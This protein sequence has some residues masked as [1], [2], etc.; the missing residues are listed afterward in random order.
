MSG[1]KSK[2]SGEF[3]EKIV[4]ELL[5][6]IGWGN[7]DFNPTIDCIDEEHKRKS[8]KHGLDF[9]FS[10][11][12]S[13]IN[14]IQDDVLISVKHNLDRYPNS[15]TS[16]FKEYLKDLSQAM[17]CFPYDTIYSEKQISNHILENQ[18]S[19]VL[20]W[21]SSKD[22]ME[23]DIV[24][25]VNL[26]R[27]TEK[28]N[29]G[30][31]YLVDNKRANFLYKTINYSKKKFGGYKFFYHT[32]GYNDN[33]PYVK[34]D[35][36]DKLPVQLINTNILPIRVD[37]TNDG[38]TLLLFINE[39]FNEKSLKRVMGFSQRLTHSWAKNIIILFPDYLEV[40]HKNVVQ[41][42]KRLFDNGDFIQTIKVQS[43]IENIPSLGEE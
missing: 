30:P 12:S 42:V 18:V 31:I 17:E 38:P 10:L 36:G 39:S 43:F 14:H 20:F 5:R 6:L 25:E 28:I 7:A 37:P 41:S 3:G 26:F 4:T 24:K 13:L 27:N 32:T 40:E 1:E 35:F 19:G 29:Y 8:K 33:D 23:K 11:E 2:S 15:P 34:K 21:I 16:K 22:D 9:V